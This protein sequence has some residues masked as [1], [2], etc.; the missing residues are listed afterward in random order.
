MVFNWSYAQ[1]AMLLKPRIWAIK[2]RNH[3]S[4][5]GGNPF[6][7]LFV[8]V[9]GAL[10]WGGLFAAS[11]RVLSY[12]KGI[13]ELGDL[14]AYKLLSMI[15]ITSFAL[16]GFSSILNSLSRLYLSRDLHLVHCLP[17][18]RHHLFAARFIDTTVD[19]SWMVVLYTL[20]VFIAYGIIFNSPLWFY[21]VCLVVLGSLAVIASALG[22]VLV[23]LAVIVI[24]ANRMK[25]IVVLLGIA[26]FVALY[27]AFR[28]LRPELLVDPDVFQSVLGYMNTL[29]TPSSPYLPTTWAFDGLKAALLGSTRSSMF[30]L[31]L[32]ISGSGVAVCLGLLTADLIYFKG[33]SRT[34][35]ASA[36]LIRA[37]DRLSSLLGFLK[38]SLRAIVVK[39]LR[40]FFRDQTQWSQLFLLSA[41]VVIYLYNFNVL[42][43]EK[44]PIQTVYLQNLLS[45]LN[46]GLALFVLSAVTARFAY[47]AVSNEKEAFWLVRS[48]PVTIS[49]FL[50]IKF[51]IYFLPLLVLTE[52]LIIATNLLLRVT[53]FMMVLSTVTVFCLVPGIVALGIGLGAAYPDFKAENPVQTVTSFGGLLFML[54]CAGL[55]GAVILLE[56]G[57]VYNL[58]MAEI[59][60]RLITSGRWIWI[61][62]AFAI[63]FGLALTALL[64]PMKYGARRLA[65]R[66]S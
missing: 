15:L 65:A 54:L 51:A 11:L 61:I 13:E 25:S 43:L 58:F 34:Q 36:R 41:L 31:G 64:L 39:E 9:L 24:P 20:P 50:W 53:P 4:N 6:R 47:P 10:F 29:R 48:A 60:G 37:G 35:T 14:L 40:T 18:E 2:N 38:P 46:M 32:C 57:P 21:G 19:S 56:A 33:F 44:S 28:M 59:R 8:G 63:A 30:H 17:V 12:F 55:I 52:V 49:T 62:S 27:I 3:V 7:L 26:A 66:S 23:M 45:F 1:V 16:L 22:A 42:P 5:G